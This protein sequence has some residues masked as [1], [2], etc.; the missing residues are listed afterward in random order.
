MTNSVFPYLCPKCN[1]QYAGIG[2]SKQ[3]SSVQYPLIIKCGHTL[4]KSCIETAARLD[5]SIVCSICEE[6]T[7]LP[8]GQKSVDSLLSDLYILGRLSVPDQ[9]FR[10]RPKKEKDTSKLN[11]QSSSSNN[12]K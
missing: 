3:V 12:G 11:L 10:E 7:E 2:T 1:R 8:D 4:C 5:K 6:K 9:N